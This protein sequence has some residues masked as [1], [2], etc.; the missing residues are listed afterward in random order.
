MAETWED[1]P[2]FAPKGTEIPRVAE[3]DTA[4][5]ISPALGALSHV[6]YDEESPQ[7]ISELLRED[8]NRLFR[9]GKR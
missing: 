9:R 6:L 7:E 4:E 5:G 3:G 1:L 2:L 8:G